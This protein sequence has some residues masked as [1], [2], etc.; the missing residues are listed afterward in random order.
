MP[1]YRE[2]V[3]PWALSRL[4]ADALHAAHAFRHLHAVHVRCHRCT[5]KCLC[6]YLGPL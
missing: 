1:V 5:W 6:V 4:H 3:G 2:Y